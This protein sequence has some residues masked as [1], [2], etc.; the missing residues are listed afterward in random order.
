MNGSGAPRAL[1][2]VR[3]I[4]LTGP[5]GQYCGKLYAD[6]GAEVI[7]IEPPEGS[8][9]RS[10]GPFI[11]DVEGPDTSIPFL[12]EN[13]GKRS[14]IL[15]LDAREGQDRLKTL[16]KD[17]DLI[18]ETARPGTMAARGLGYDVLAAI[19]P[20]LVYVSIT[21]FGQTGP[22]ADYMADDLTLLALGGLLHL[23]GYPDGA[24]QTISGEQGYHA[25]SLFGA[26]ASMAAVISAERTG[27]GEYIDVSMHEAVVMG[28]ENAAQFYDLEGVVR[29]R[30][31]GF[32]TLGGQLPCKDGYIYVM[33]GGVSGGKTWNNVI[34]WMRAA[35]A[36]EAEILAEPRWD[37][38][39]YRTSEEGKAEF[40]RVF[41][42][43]SMKHSREELY[44]SGKRARVPM[45]P[46]RTAADVLR[47]DQLAFRDFF[48][49][50]PVPAA[51]RG[52]TM[53]GAPYRLSRTPWGIAGPAPMAGEHQA[54]TWEEARLC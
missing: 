48:A 7:L 5:E 46:V 9:G 13:S 12:Y 33:V 44:E 43:F 22:Y 35:G 25:A 47:S 49:T 34:E 41:A 38:D 31:A 19:N 1:A 30:A 20:R 2:G 11:D 53:P 8:P 27:R 15:D 54:E 52:I 17:A 29:P 40:K 3:V 16:V 50:V 18:I 26:V 28:L 37:A 4:D 32:R 6:M 24:P 14:I 21:P 42:G 36:P 23:G 45:A 39:G 10:I 51:G